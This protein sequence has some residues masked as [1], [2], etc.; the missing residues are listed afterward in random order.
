[1]LVHR[2]DEGA[3]QVEDHGV[4]AGLGCCGV[5]VVPVPGPPGLKRAVADP[6]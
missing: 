6:T 4:E 3:V 5:H 2:V 1:V